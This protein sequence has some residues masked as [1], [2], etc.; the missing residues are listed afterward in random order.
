MELSIPMVIILTKYKGNIDIKLLEKILG[1]NIIIYNKD[2]CKN[3]DS[4]LSSNNSNYNRFKKIDDIYLDINYRYN[5]ID[6]IT[7]KVVK[8]NTCKDIII[9]NKYLSMIIS[10]LLF[11]LV[12]YV[13]I[14]IIG[15]NCI[16]IVSN[17]INNVINYIS[18][19]L[20]SLDISLIF[21]EKEPY[22]VS[23]IRF[24]FLSSIKT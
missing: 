2:I 8:N 16:N 18:N 1:I 11:I 20:N 24:S 6:E 7:S 12:Y 17:I 4:V 10:I 21:K 22:E 5:K 3:I 19:Y 9:H 14:N 13:S 15:S 23:F